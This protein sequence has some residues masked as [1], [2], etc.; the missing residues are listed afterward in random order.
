MSTAK[1][2]LLTLK[3][4]LETGQST[5][6]YASIDYTADDVRRDIRTRFER[7]KTA[8]AHARS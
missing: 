1:E 8:E 5:F 2:Q 7:Y 6:R 4:D 3:H